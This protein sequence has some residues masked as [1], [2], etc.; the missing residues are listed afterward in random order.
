M[1]DSNRNGPNHR[2]FIAIV[3]V[4]SV[5]GFIFIMAQPKEQ[6]ASKDPIVSEAT[7]SIKTISTPTKIPTALPASP[8]Y[9]SP[10]Q[11]NT[12]IE[13]WRYSFVNSCA[14]NSSY[15][16]CECDFD[17]LITHYGF[18]WLVRENTNIEAFGEV[19]YAQFNAAATACRYYR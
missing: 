16:S 7:S 11:F 18:I 17:Y 3:I 13:S 14:E 9:Y 5:A 12:N 10:M 6:N 8:P 1:E 4:S 15:S 19:P 2:L